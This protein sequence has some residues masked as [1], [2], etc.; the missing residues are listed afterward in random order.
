VAE[1]VIRNL[2][3]EFGSFVA[4]EDSTFTVGDG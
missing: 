3:K 4:V 2:R 1:I